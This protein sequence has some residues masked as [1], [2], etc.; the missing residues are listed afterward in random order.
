MGG[1]V[2]LTGPE[3]VNSTEL[4]NAKFRSYYVVMKGVQ[5]DISTAVG[6]MRGGG[7]DTGYRNR[8]KEVGRGRHQ[9]EVDSLQAQVQMGPT[10]MAGGDPNIAKGGK[11]EKGEGRGNV[12]VLWCVMG[13]YTVS[14][15]LRGVSP[16]ADSPISAERRSCPTQRLTPAWHCVGMNPSGPTGAGNTKRSPY[17]KGGLHFTATG[18]QSPSFSA[19]AAHY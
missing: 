11:G 4:L 19:P 17:L 16:H 3:T 6:E 5:N 8:K 2:G 10:I 7:R 15:G 12:R 18:H 13:G 9:I 14:A 1:F